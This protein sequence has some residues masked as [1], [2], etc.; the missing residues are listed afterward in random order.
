MK[1]NYL[2]ALNEM[3]EKEVGELSTNLFVENF[4]NM[5]D[6][7]KIINDALFRLKIPFCYSN[8]DEFCVDYKK[9]S[10]IVI[11]EI[12]KRQDNEVP[13][14]S[15]VL[16]K[17]MIDKQ[18]LFGNPKNRESILNYISQLAFKINTEELPYYESLDAAFDF[19]Y[20]NKSRYHFEVYKQLLE[21]LEGFRESKTA[22]DNLNNSGITIVDFIA[23]LSIYL[24]LRF[25][26]AQRAGLSI[27]EWFLVIR[28]VQIKDELELLSKHGHAKAIYSGEHGL[29]S[30]QIDAFAKDHI[31]NSFNI[32]IVGD[33][34]SICDI[35]AQ[36]QQ[37]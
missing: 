37:K 34:I 3:I 23:E 13:E 30:Y 21:F 11:K 5:N 14:N 27:D 1:T 31:F 17:M 25:E 18:I 22:F 2:T 29:N 16:Q 32:K 9:N 10:L 4:K 12:Q 28:W 6:L 26:I 33:E 19:V 35:P 15:G 20:D 36:K 7:R 8:Y 24:Q